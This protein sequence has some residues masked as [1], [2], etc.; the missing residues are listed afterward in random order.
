MTLKEREGAMKHM[1]PSVFKARCLSIIRGI[2]S[3]GEPVLVTKRGKPWVKVIRVE[4]ERD[5]LSSGTG[6]SKLQAKS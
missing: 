4:A 6:R 3:T 1:P 5:V 2:Q